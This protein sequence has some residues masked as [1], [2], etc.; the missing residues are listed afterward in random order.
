M[1]TL[2]NNE[3]EMLPRLHLIKFIL[4]EYSK[5]FTRFLL[6]SHYNQSFLSNI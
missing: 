6:P 1:P 2:E 5:C 3:K 4:K